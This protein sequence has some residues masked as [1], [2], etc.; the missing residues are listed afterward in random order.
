M[1]ALVAFVYF[2]ENLAYSFKLKNVAFLDVGLISFGF[3]LRVLAGGIATDVHVSGYMLACT[4][5]SEPWNGSTEYT[6]SVV[7]LKTSLPPW[8]VARLPQPA[9]VTASAITMQ[10]ADRG[11]CT[12]IKRFRAWPRRAASAPRD[13][14]PILWASREGPAGPFSRWHTPRSRAA[15]QAG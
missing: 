4:A 6:V 5:L 10:A 2:A 8:T 7:A 15:I 13:R 12:W 3:V 14:G 9:S 11:V 1:L